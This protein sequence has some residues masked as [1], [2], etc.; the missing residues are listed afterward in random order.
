MSTTVTASTDPDEPNEDNDPGERDDSAESIQR[1]LNRQQDANRRL[2]KAMPPPSPAMAPGDAL[3]RQILDAESKRMLVDEELA[4]ATRD[5]LRKLPDVLDAKAADRQA[6][7]SDRL[8]ATIAHAE[9][10]IREAT[11]KVDEAGIRFLIHLYGS[12][13]LA[14]VLAG[15]LFLIFITSNR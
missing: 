15:F 1:L 5:T 11:P 7:F 8:D 13:T 2:E 12:L 14:L 9:R 6:V 3:Q 10:S 4:A